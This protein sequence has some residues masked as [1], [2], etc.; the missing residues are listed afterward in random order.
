M[1]VAHDRAPE[2]TLTGWDVELTG[3]PGVRGSRDAGS[4][5]GAFSMLPGLVQQPV[6]LP[7]GGLILRE[8]AGQR[9]QRFAQD[10]RRGSTVH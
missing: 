1:A 10:C 8:Q 6:Q 2:R 4:G 3:D 5:L 9:A 7:F